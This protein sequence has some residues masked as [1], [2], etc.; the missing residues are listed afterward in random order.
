M[1]YPSSK[2][3]DAVQKLVD[4]QAMRLRLLLPD[5]LNGKTKPVENYWDAGKILYETRIAVSSRLFLNMCDMC[6]ISHGSAQEYISIHRHFTRE[7]ITEF[8]FVT[9]AIDRYRKERYA[10]RT[11]ESNDSEALQDC[12][13]I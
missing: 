2:F 4:I 10:P 7:D 1:K 3:E 13:G 9:K 6:S 11:G 12:S 5:R 8:R